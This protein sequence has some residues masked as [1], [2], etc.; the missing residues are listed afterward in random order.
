MKVPAT[1]IYVFSQALTVPG[2]LCLGAVA[3]NAVGAPSLEAIHMPTRELKRGSQ[4]K[5]GISF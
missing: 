1:S 5:M 4:Q 3:G 2:R